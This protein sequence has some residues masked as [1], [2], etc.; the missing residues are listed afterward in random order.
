MSAKQVA[1]RDKLSVLL[2]AAV[3]DRVMWLQSELYS[4]HPEFPGISC[5]QHKRKWDVS[6]QQITGVHWRL[7]WSLF[8]NK[9]ETL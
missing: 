2:I 9:W 4:N 1:I 3:W 5:R 6:G 7:I 8:I